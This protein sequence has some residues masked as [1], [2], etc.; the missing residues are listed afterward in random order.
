LHQIGRR[1]GVSHATPVVAKPVGAGVIIP[2]PY[3]SRTDWC[4]NVLAAGGC[5][6]T[7]NGEELELTAPELIRSSV[8]EPLVPAR[9]AAV[10]RRLGIQQYL[11]LKKVSAA[12]AA[13]EVIAVAA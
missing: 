6:I 2:L 7:L 9:N 12:A 3:G 1:T 5:S 8:A 13:K 10:W 4:R 11:R